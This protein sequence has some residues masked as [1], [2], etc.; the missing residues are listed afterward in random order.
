MWQIKERSDGRD[1]NQCRVG[2]S[3]QF[4]PSDAPIIIA[5]RFVATPA[6][7]LGL[8]DCETAVHQSDDIAVPDQRHFM[9]PGNPDTF[10]CGS[11]RQC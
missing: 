4:V 1:F 5:Q 9:I 3:P 10:G 2:G 8:F 6:V 7:R 11:D